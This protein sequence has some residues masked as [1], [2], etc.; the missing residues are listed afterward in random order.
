MLS[1]T[2]GRC[3]SSGSCTNRRGP[4]CIWEGVALSH[5]PRQVLRA[6]CPAPPPSSELA[7]QL[8]LGGLHQGW[9]CLRSPRFSPL[10]NGTCVVP[11][12][13]WGK[14]G[15][16]VREVPGSLE[17]QLCAGFLHRVLAVPL[18]PA[19]LLQESHQLGSS[20]PLQEPRPLSLL[21]LALAPPGC[22]RSPSPRVGGNKLSSF[23]LT[24]G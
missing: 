24:I 7:G 13:A 1:G 9:G 6:P 10:G 19:A 20:S 23:M 5:A 4:C 18:L 15:Q 11:G 17:R 16:E 8:G 21:R 2:G 3:P 14:A 12:T 22:R